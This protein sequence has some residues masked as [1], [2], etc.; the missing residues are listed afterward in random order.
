VNVCPYL[1]VCNNIYALI[2]ANM[3]KRIIVDEYLENEHRKQVQVYNS[4][5][6]HFNRMHPL[7]TPCTKK[8]RSS[9][10]EIEIG[11]SL[12]KAI[13]VEAKSN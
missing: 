13:G 12:M 11:S 7:V 6:L 1:I 10:N 4:L 8:G 3:Y 5:S 2:Y 9:S